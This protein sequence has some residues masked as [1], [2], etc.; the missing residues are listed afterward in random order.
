MLPPQYNAIRMDMDFE[1]GLI[2]HIGSK[3]IIMHLNTFKQDS[4]KYIVGT[5]P[6]EQ[7]YIEFAD[8]E[9]VPFNSSVKCIAKPKKYLR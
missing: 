2:H 9:E 1:T 3:A 8:R 5:Y 7:T 4:D 6:K